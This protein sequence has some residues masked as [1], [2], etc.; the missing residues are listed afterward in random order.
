LAFYGLLSFYHGVEKDLE[1]CDPWPKF[2]C[3]KGVVFLTFWQSVAIQIMSTLGF[4]DEKAASQIQNL[5][6]CIEMLIASIA[7][8]YIFPYQEWAEGYQR[9]KQRNILLRDTMAFSDFLKDMKTMFTRDLQDSNVNEETSILKEESVHDISMHSLP[10]KALTHESSPII[11]GHKGSL[12]SVENELITKEALVRKALEYRLAQLSELDK[13]EKLDKS[14]HGTSEKR[15][16]I[17]PLL[18]KYYQ[19]RDL[20]NNHYDTLASHDDS[21]SIREDLEDY[22]YETKESV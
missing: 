18:S 21:I 10:D 9:A 12:S 11:T 2:L 17:N 7:H 20:A 13:L 15:S 6:I 1:W 3:I 16:S 19:R 5:L 4:V 8:F 22:P 14:S